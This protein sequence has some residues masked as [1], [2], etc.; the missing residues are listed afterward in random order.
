M[1]TSSWMTPPNLRRK[2]MCAT[3]RITRMQCNALCILL[4]RQ[5]AVDYEQL[6]R[7]FNHA[8]PLT[9]YQTSW[10]CCISRYADLFIYETR[11][12]MFIHLFTR[13]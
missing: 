7:V 10:P 2:S 4:G 11:T 6:Y 5:N 8:R 9:M 13:L 1:W 3:V 12:D